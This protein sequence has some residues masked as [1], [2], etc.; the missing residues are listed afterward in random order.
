[1]LSYR[2]NLTLIIFIS[3]CLLTNC[4]KDKKENFNTK[5]AND[6]ILNKEWKIYSATV[7]PPFKIN[8]K[9][10]SDLYE[11]YSDCEKDN[12]IK[13]FK[14]STVIYD[15]GPT[16][17]SPN[18]PQNRENTWFFTNNDTYIEEGGSKLK[19]IELND[20][21]LTVASEQKYSGSIYVFTFYFKS[22]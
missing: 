10:V 19:I 17:C 3:A 21:K 1:M 12:F 11:N 5:N 7:N 2:I 9:Y 6:Y 20:N 22:N 4:K 13:Y 16:K 14:D 18:A 15:E 8:N